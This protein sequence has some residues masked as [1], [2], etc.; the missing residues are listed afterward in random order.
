MEQLSA[1]EERFRSLV[2]TIP[3]IVYKIDEKGRFTFLNKSIE[4]LGYH[5]ADLI[6]KH[7]SE[8][9]HSADLNEV[10]LERVLERF[11]NGTPNP[12]QKLFNERRSGVRMTVGMEIRLKL[13]NG[14]SNRVYEIRNIGQDVISVEVNS[15]GLYGENRKETSRCT[16][17]YVGTVG[18][19]RDI[20]D[21]LKIQDAFTEERKLLRQLID[22][23]PLPIFFFESQGKLIFSNDAF[24]KFTGIDGS[25]LDEINMNELFCVDDQPKIYSI[26][27]SLLENQEDDRIHKRIELKSSDD[28]SRAID[29]ILLKFQKSDQAT[30]AIIGVL[31]DF[32]EQKAFTTRLIQA[33]KYAEEMAGKAN[34]ASHAKGEFLANMSHE[35]RT[36][37]N[38]VI[39]LT[40]LCLQTELTG[41]QRDYLVKVSVSAN[42]L[43]Q[44]I[45]DILDFSKIE[46]GKLTMEAVEFTL[47]EVLGGV[48]AALSVKS[49]EK[50]LEMLLD[51]K[52]NVPPCLQGDPHR[53]G[54]ILT[55]LVGNA[56]KFTE[57]GEVSITIEVMEET[58]ESALLQFTVRDTGIG[59]TPEQ[60]SKLFQEFSQGDTSIT[61]KYGG[62]GLGLAI[63]KRLV[64]MMGGRIV[65]ANEPGR[66]S[67][68]TFTARFNKVEVP[69]MEIFMPSDNL[70]GMHILVVDDNEGARQIIAEHLEALSYH[71]V[72]VACGEE[73]IEAIV[74]ADREN[75]GFDLV[76]M[77][78]R[79]PGMSGMEA[80]RHIKK[81]LSLQK[82][83]NVIMVT[84]Y[85]QEYIESSE[86]EK[87][88]LDGF[89][90]KPVH[91]T[92]LLDVIMIVFGYE[93]TRQ[94]VSRSNNPFASLAGARVLLAED[95][96]INQQVAQELLEQ[97]GIEVV[98]A[99]NGQEAVALASREHFDA[100]LMDLQ[101]PIMDG[102]TATKHI[103]SEKSAEVLPII[104]MT[105]NAMSGD[106]EK[107]LEEG[108]NDHIAKPVDP[109]MMY[110]TLARW[111][112]SRPD[113]PL[114][115]PV[116]SHPGRVK[117][118]VLPIP[119]LTGIDLAR[120]MRNLGDNTTL[121]RKVLLKFALNQGGA[122]LGMER[123]LASGDFTTLEQIAHALKGVSAT[124]GILKLADLAGR[125]EKQSVNPAGLKELPELV[126][127]ISKELARIVSTIETTLV[128]ETS[129]VTEEEQPG[130]DVTPEELAPLFRKAVRLLIDFDSSAERV[131][132]DIAHLA[133]SGVRRK[134][135]ESI[136]VALG[137]YDFEIC[138]SLF[139]AWA[140][141]EGIYL[142]DNQP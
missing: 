22:A 24:Q 116:L 110:A 56:I 126:V 20:T 45:N 81:E 38:G 48:V 75:S 100:I 117:G 19:I 127:K 4:R 69:V 8:I 72:C 140:K 13:K 29:V 107:C 78:W 7:F 141:E 85:G 80:V 6:G 11:G 108:M 106:R 135:L 97:A 27:S 23:V 15:T 2:Q 51:T 70:R 39:G 35:I 103:R 71:P 136:K 104:A 14:R 31:V 92:S 125:I 67:R 95:N 36:P 53:L 132:E 25:N 1:S 64:E 60:V 28:Q 74:A 40:H 119:P 34:L 47:D 65:V 130:A 46:A 26:V 105:A 84:A 90:M 79:M 18:V 121:Y 52:R 10:S 83:P 44:L 94:L 118:L 112:P 134:R 12:E 42:T 57:K 59:M 101:M 87:S 142:E 123:C 91:I 76:L 89:L 82:T 120:G 68:F 5:Q 137:V 98:I 33:K 113:L 58:Q 30:P 62:T 41:Q 50:R 73:A 37:L 114:Q 133:R 96:E 109:E 66:G 102:L 115:P 88:L 16:R 21:R 111:L 139:L 61:R 9:I 99:N 93:P 86:E 124:L 131:V 54:Q 3:D 43:L 17:Q 32:T 49:H 129:L 55:N 63:S 138:L 122:C 77:D 128:Q